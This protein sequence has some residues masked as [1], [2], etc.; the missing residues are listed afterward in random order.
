MLGEGQGGHAEKANDLQPEETGRIGNH[1]WSIRFKVAEAAIPEDPGKPMEGG[2]RE[3]C[4]N[5]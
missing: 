5:L 1:H 4:A 2:A 3:C